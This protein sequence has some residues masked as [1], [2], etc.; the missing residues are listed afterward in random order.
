MIKM[1][2][3]CKAGAV[4]ALAHVFGAACGGSDE[5]A[6]V[7]ST[8]S[9]SSSVPETKATGFEAA[10]DE[11][12][13]DLDT[14]PPEV[15]KLASAEFCGSERFDGVLR[16]PGVEVNEA[17]RRCFLDR[18]RSDQSAVFV[19]SQNSIEGDPIVTIYHSTRKGDVALFVDATRDAFGSGEWESGT[20]EGVTTEFP[21]APQ[22]LPD[23][24]FD[25]KNCGPVTP[26]A[27]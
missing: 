19:M 10:L 21:D 15:T 12:G 3:M 18:Y 8:T 24:Y 14:A 6:A 13:V 27:G 1:S 26:A 16:S 23:S 11:L 17:A 25:V 4:V 22:P 20:C 9:S 7:P 5:G 2:Q